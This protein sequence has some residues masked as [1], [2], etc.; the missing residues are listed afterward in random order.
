MDIKT[1]E[2]H[3]CIKCNLKTHS[4]WLFFVRKSLLFVEKPT[5]YIRFEEIGQIEFQ[6]L[7]VTV[8]KLFDMRVTLSKGDKKVAPPTFVGIEREH[9]EQLSEYFKAGGVKV[10]NKTEE[11]RAILKQD[12]EPSD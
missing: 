5:L 1:R 9:L 7:N 2:G 12:I 6:R 3:S 11:K 10:I 8:N 4:G